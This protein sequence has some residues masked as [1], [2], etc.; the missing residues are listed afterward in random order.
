MFLLDT[1]VV[2]ELRRIRPHGVIVAWLGIRDFQ[3]FG[4]RTLDPFR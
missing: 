4:V 2:S 3:Y 1:N